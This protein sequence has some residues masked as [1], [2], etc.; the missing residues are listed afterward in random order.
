MTDPAK[1]TA[2]GEHGPPPVSLPGRL[3]AAVKAHP[4]LS[5][6][7]LAAFVRLLA[8]FYAKGFMASDD[9]F[10][11]IRP[12]ADWLNGLHTWFDSGRPVAR[13]V[14]YPYSIYA[15]F[16]ILK[17]LG[18][19]DPDRVM[20]VNR[21]LHAAW[22]LA[23]IPLVYYALRAWADER[24]AWMGGL[25]AAL[26][27]VMPFMAVRN[28][29]EVVS[30]PLLL[31]G[32]LL[33]ERALRGE[34][35]EVPAF[36]GGVL[37]GVSFMIRIQTAVCGLAVFWVLLA[38]RRYRLVVTFSAGALLMVLVA[39][40]IDYI[41][42][43]MFLSSVIF[44]LGYQAARVHSYVTSPWYAHL[45]T[46]L[47][48]FIPPFSLLFFAWVARAAKRLPVLFWA[49]VVF[50]AVHSL[51]PQK[52]ERFL[53]PILPVLIVLGMTGWSMVRWRDRGWVR[54]L[55]AWFWAVNLLLLPVGIFNYSQKARVE[56]LVRLGRRAD[57]GGVVAVTIEN[58]I[59]LP[60]Y[61]MGWKGDDFYYVFTQDEIARLPERI[62]DGD[63]RGLPP[64]T[65]LI[66]FTHR[67]PE[68]YLPELEAV[69]GPLELEEH[70]GPSLADA[71]LHRLNPRFN[72]S[73]ESWVYRLAR[74]ADAALNDEIRNP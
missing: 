39:G 11:V 13:G 45:L 32:L 24:A 68:A 52:Q 12:A 22:S 72:H 40:L 35:G 54:G 34:K 49:A 50:V 18:I 41:S 61:Y 31:A 38:L 46:L 4:L 8:A 1:R 27:A 59:W 42:W 37:I 17:L 3:T 55:W 28:L 65:H 69:L 23:L 2:G 67:D 29:V 6:I 48:A 71:I 62:A 30:Q 74:P 26:Y 56:P 70:V 58:P 47:V 36:W 33:A 63:E 16:Y 44:T 73:K 60:Y 15:L 53:L 19:T 14:L 66:L 9:H 7:L 21:L 5:L 43:G 64:P 20:L 25:M 10:A 57:V 51:I